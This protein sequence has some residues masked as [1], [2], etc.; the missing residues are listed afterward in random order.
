MF[1]YNNRYECY[2]QEE[3][4]LVQ[5]TGHPLVYRWKGKEHR[6]SNYYNEAQNDVMQHCL[7]CCGLVEHTCTIWRIGS[8]PSTLRPDYLQVSWPILIA[9]LCFFLDLH[10]F[11]NTFGWYFGLQFWPRFACQLDCAEMNCLGLKFYCMLPGFLVLPWT[12]PIH[13]LLSFV[14]TC[15]WASKQ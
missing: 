11:P 10:F 12:A 13:L 15:L 6:L 1:A 4:K 3:L 14:Y 9:Y 8:T 7:S 5:R 2:R